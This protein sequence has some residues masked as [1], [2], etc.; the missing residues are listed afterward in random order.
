MAELQI[1]DI[2]RLAHAT[3]VAAASREESLRC[4]GRL[5]AAVVCR[6]SGPLPCG[7][8]PWCKRSP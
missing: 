3:V 5:A 1:E 7:V 6:S 2:R 4:A 8:C